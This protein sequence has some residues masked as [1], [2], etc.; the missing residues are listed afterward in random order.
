VRIRWQKN[1]AWLNVTPWCARC[2]KLEFD[3]SCLFNLWRCPI[4]Y[5]KK[6][7]F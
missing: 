2:K 5:M 6:G 4:Y 1:W 7:G 3:S